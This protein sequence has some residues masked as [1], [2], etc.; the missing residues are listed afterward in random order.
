M[1]YYYEGE[2]KDGMMHGKGRKIY[3]DGSYYIG[4]FRND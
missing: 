4:N 2:F 3:Q 1:E